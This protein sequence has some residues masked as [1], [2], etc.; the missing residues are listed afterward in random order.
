MPL[1]RRLGRITVLAGAAA[2]FVVF[3]AAVAVA[4][5]GSRWG[6]RSQDE[7]ERL[8]P[9]AE[10]VEAFSEAGAWL[11]LAELPRAVVGNDGPY[12]GASAYRYDGERATL[13]VLVCR[14]RCAGVPA[15][16][17][18]PLAIDNRYLRQFSALGNNVAIFM[19]D[20]DRRS[21]GQ[22]QARFQHV[23][24]D[25]DVAEDPGSRCSIQ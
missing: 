1:P 12:Q 13:W 11:S 24:N 20:N 9:P 7:L 19:T 25:F 21:G 8:R 16:L 22:L 14:A 3:A 18:R 4:S 17:D 10:I 23:V 2:V 6:C 5:S 15:G